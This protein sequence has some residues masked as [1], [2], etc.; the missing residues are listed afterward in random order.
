MTSVTPYSYDAPFFGKIAGIPG[1]L[2]QG[3]V[4]ALGIISA[5]Q[6]LGPMF[7]LR[8]ET[9][10]A[11]TKSS[12][13]GVAVWKGLDIGAEGIFNAIPEGG[14]KTWINAIHVDLK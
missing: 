14:I 1:H 9:V 4:W 3:A 2:V 11:A 5:I 6:L 8:E 7:G 13:V 10:S 12:L